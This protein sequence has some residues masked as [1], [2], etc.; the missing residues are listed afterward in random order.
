MLHKK[1]FLVK[2]NRCYDV[3][4]FSKTVLSNHYLIGSKEQK[5]LC[6]LFII[7]QFSESSR[8]SAC[9]AAGDSAFLYMV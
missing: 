2:G 7:W 1:T 8:T 9:R 5:N 6:N 3:H 4:M